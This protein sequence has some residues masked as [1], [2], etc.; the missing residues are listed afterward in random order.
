M[1]QGGKQG[2]QSTLAAES[3]SAFHRPALEVHHCHVTQCRTN[4]AL[5]SLKPQ[6][7]PFPCG[8][9]GHYD[10]QLAGIKQALE[11][12]LPAKASQEIEAQ[13]NGCSASV[14]RFLNLRKGSRHGLSCDGCAQQGAVPGRRHAG[15]SDRSSLLP[16]L[17]CECDRAS[18]A[19]LSV[20]AGSPEC[21]LIRLA[22][23][24]PNE[25]TG[26]RKLL[27]RQ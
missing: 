16:S 25:E 21:R 26:A 9:A 15:S 24:S 7:S 1:Q 17:G 8:P 5:Q 6:G 10:W 4:D 13:L 20:F 19:S 12:C 22:A 18:Q 2:H 23:R 11:V 27:T 3:I 14:M